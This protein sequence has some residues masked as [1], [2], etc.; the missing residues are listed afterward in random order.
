VG[1]NDLGSLLGKL[2]GKID[3]Q[4]TVAEGV[5]SL[6]GSKFP[7][8]KP[9]LEGFMNNIKEAEKLIQKQLNQAELEKLFNTVSNVR[10][11]LKTLASTVLPQI[12]LG[13]SR[14]LTAAQSEAKGL[15]NQLEGIV[16]DFLVGKAEGLYKE[17]LK[18][19]GEQ[20][21]QFIAKAQLILGALYTQQDLDADLLRGKALDLSNKLNNF[22]KSKP[23]LKAKLDKLI[24]S[25]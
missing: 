9:S 23:Q 25:S 16:T 19:A 5:V 2:T 6:L 24:K 10:T 13:V 11:Q 4:I 7:Q 12:K 20:Q 15:F 3:P 18:K 21:D 17:A 22:I 8:L 14:K 1:A